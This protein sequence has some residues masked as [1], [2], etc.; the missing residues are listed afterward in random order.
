MP[1]TPYPVCAEFCP[2]GHP[3]GVPV[4]HFRS[5]VPWRSLGV[6]LRRQ[7]LWALL[8]RMLRSGRLGVV[9]P[10]KRMLDQKELAKRVFGAAGADGADGVPLTQQGSLEWY[11]TRAL[12]ERTRHQDDRV[13]VAVIKRC[14]LHLLSFK[15]PDASRLSKLEY[16]QT[17]LAL[18]R[19]LL[20]DAPRL[21]TLRAADKDWA[22]DS[23]GAHEL[24]YRDFH[25]AMYELVDQWADTTNVLEYRQLSYRLTSAVEKAYS[26]P[27]DSLAAELAAAVGGGDARYG[28][29]AAAGYGGGASD[30]GSN[31][32][33]DG[34]GSGVGA[35]HR[36]GSTADGG[37]GA[38]GAGSASASTIGPASA[39]RNASPTHRPGSSMS[40]VWPAP[41]MSVA[42][43]TPLLTHSG[44]GTGAAGKDSA[45][46]SCDGELPSMSRRFSLH[47]ASRFTSS[48]AEDAVDL[49]E[50][51]WLEADIAAAATAAAAA[52]VSGGATGGDNATRTVHPPAEQPREVVVRRDPSAALTLQLSQPALDQRNAWFVARSAKAQSLM[53]QRIAL[54]GPSPLKASKY[55][56]ARP[57]M[58]RPGRPRATPAPGNPAIPPDRLSLSARCAGASVGRP[59]AARHSLPLD[60]RPVPS[61]VR[62]HRSRPPTAT[63]AAPAPTP[64]FVVP[65][66]SDA[67]ERLLAVAATPRTRL[68]G[69]SDRLLAVM[70]PGLLQAAGASPASVAAAAAAP[71]PTAV[72]RRQRANSDAAQA[73]VRSAAA[74]YDSG[75]LSPTRSRPATAP[76]T[77]RPVAAAGGNTNLPSTT[78][79]GRDGRPRTSQMRLPVPSP[80]DTTGWHRR[81]RPLSAYVPPRRRAPRIA[82]EPVGAG[83]LAPTGRWLPAGALSRRPNAASVSTLSSQFDN[84]GTGSVDATPPTAPPAQDDE[85]ALCVDGGAL[86][87]PALSPLA[88]WGPR[89][90]GHV[91]LLSSPSKPAPAPSGDGQPL[92][93][94]ADERL[95]AKL[96]ASR[97][98]SV[99]M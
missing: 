2:C 14:W 64:Q 85:D 18:S 38:A 7:E 33:G 47:G 77:R 9:I 15:G 50:P 73:T 72:K 6:C 39:S 54:A 27:S 34:D 8:R 59:A 12:A 28:G 56:R 5:V 70:H 91:E 61:P 20:P 24:A 40:D 75:M 45:Q 78:G 89:F 69:L 29:G 58:R 57:P 79:S 98:R 99:T 90:Q 46:S 36:R 95:A 65:R 43:S 87:M 35:G 21:D 71:S 80:S 30:G 48:S 81:E 94:L 62:L 11:N 97:T 49:S 82:L 41:D 88:R 63:G 16:V 68:G 3:A 17:I 53:Q 60:S 86:G 19:V 32:D 83:C 52:A 42:M 25:D 84:L 76:A 10:K 92:E 26:P 23:R 51:A 74:G 96:Y 13:V 55:H 37:S 93:V 66:D 22:Q 44:T 1:T 4:R 67:T 31:G